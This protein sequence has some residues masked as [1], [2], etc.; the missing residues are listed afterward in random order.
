MLSAGVSRLG[1]ESNSRNIPHT[2]STEFYKV[3]ILD[4][5]DLNAP[6]ELVSPLLS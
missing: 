1:K 6:S 4:V 2:L 3:D 5:R